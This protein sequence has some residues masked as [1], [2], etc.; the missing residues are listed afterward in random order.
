LT[1]S[2]GIR[3]PP[4]DR[5]QRVAEAAAAAEAGRFD[6]VWT[7]D[8]PLLAGVL[9]DPY[10]ALA[11]CAAT[12][13]RVRLGVAVT[14][15]FT[16]HVAVT[17]A[18]ALGLDDL[19]RGRA[20]LGLGSG[21]SAMRTLGLAPADAEGTHGARRPVIRETIQTLRA[22]FAGTPLTIGGRVLPRG[23]ARRRIP[24][25]LAATGPKMLELAGEVADGVIIQVGVYPAC[26]ERALAHV[27]EGARKAG[28]SPDEIDIVCSTFTSV[29]D[30]RRL[31]IDRAR[32]LAAWFYAVAP[33]L[34]EI[35]GI[36]VGQRQPARPVFPDISHP[37]DHA[38][39]MA[40]AR[41][42][43][44]DEAVEK[45]CLVGSPA[46]CVP[47]LE[48][49]ARLGVRQVFFRH[50][51]TYEIPWSLIEA[52]S[53]EILPWFHDGRPPAATFTRRPGPPPA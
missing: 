11:A 53:R 15:P 4:C 51:L 41:R 1:L 20:V 19:S 3:I 36:Q 27:R 18:A 43:V 35:A 40:E 25:Y 17:A 28:R 14:N 5:L 37:A 39:A 49:L 21:D 23:P 33:H 29:A 44:S 13:S 24:I 10:V 47:R 31:A 2:F 52:A 12:T 38:D 34:L 26:V 32:P 22:V 46:E 45:F 16:R 48:E 30:D 7:L 9:F 50:Y 6:Y 42:Y 8:S